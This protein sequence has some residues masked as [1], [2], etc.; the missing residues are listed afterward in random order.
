MASAQGSSG[1]RLLRV[2]WGPGS[3]LIAALIGGGV[4]K[5]HPSSAE[6]G[7]SGLGLANGQVAASDVVDR[8]TLKR[9]AEGGVS[10][11]RSLDN[12]SDLVAFKNVVQT[13][14]SPWNSGSLF[15]MLITLDGSIIWHGGN[16]EVENRSLAAVEDERGKKVFP[17][18][19]A[20]AKSGG[21]FVEYHWD[22]PTRLDD[23]LRKLSYSA[24]Y[25][26]A[27][28]G[29]KLMLVAGYQ[30]DLSHIPVPIADLPRP[31]VTASEVVDRETLRIFVEESAK[32]FQAAYLTENY[33]GLAGTKN[34]FRTKGDWK[35]GGT[36]L[37]VVS[38]EGIVVFH[39][40]EQHRENKPAN[41]DRE[42]VN[43]FKFVEALFAKGAAG[44]GYVEYH[45]DNPAI[46]GD[47]EFGS[48]KIGYASSFYLPGLE[49]P[50][51]VGSGIYDDI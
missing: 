49:D 3:V 43:G 16:P 40:S 1:R 47:E 39:G 4:F 41:L 27:W 19:L 34:A 23:P 44:G 30:Q 51:I 25:S 14:G 22:D 2:A 35:D 50:F 10:H 36:Y 26:S 32:V 29:K 31:A 15:L 38:D 8:S 33:R 18:W 20:Q 42:D 37:W 12:L 24:F 9:F 7:S 6:L 48:P 17:E 45:Y 11:L 46:Q 13:E 28:S 5:A 21:G